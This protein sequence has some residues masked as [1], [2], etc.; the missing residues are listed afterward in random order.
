MVA[1]GSPTRSHMVA[2]SLYGDNRRK[3]V[4]KVPF[5]SAELWDSQDFHCSQH[6]QAPE[7]R[8]GPL[9]PLRASIQV[10]CKKFEVL[11]SKVFHLKLKVKPC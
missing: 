7:E 11:L 5:R 8:H 6:T 4:R 10:A 2:H 3:A 9:G 1:P